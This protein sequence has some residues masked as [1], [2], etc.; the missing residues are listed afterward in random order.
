MRLAFVVALGTL[1]AMSPPS[2]TAQ[3]TTG[4]VGVA[5][6]KAADAESVKLRVEDKRNRCVAAIGNRTTLCSCLS[7][8]LPLDM[9][10]SKYVALVTTE[11]AEQTEADQRSADIARVVRD[12][13]VAAAVQ[14]ER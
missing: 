8:A 12:R 1:A 2:V 6:A 3:R 14:S 13:C 9:D 7:A 10:F 4:D 5:V 11:R